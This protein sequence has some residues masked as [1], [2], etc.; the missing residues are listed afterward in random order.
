MPTLRDDQVGWASSTVTSRVFKDPSPRVECPL[1]DKPMNPAGNIGT[2]TVAHPSGRFV[3]Y[4]RTHKSC[5][6]EALPTERAD[7]DAQAIALL[8]AEL[9]RHRG[10]EVLRPH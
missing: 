6:Q 4:Y 5:A 10:L 9:E 3:A 2:H 1:C 8:D 7:L